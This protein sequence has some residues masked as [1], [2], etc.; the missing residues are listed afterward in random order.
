M[1][2]LSSLTHITRSPPSSSSPSSSSSRPRPRPRPPRPRRS[3]RRRP[4]PSSPS[5]SPSSCRRPLRPRPRRPRPR[6]LRG[7]VD[8]LS[9]LP[10]FSF[11]FFVE[12]SSSSG[13]GVSAGG[14]AATASGGIGGGVARAPI[15][16]PVASSCS[17]DGRTGVFPVSPIPA[18]ARA[19]EQLVVAAVVVTPPRRPERARPL[20]RVHAPPHVRRVGRRRR[21][22]AA[23]VVK[24]DD[25][26][27]LVG[28][29]AA[30]VEA[31]GLARLER[32]R[33]GEE[34]RHLSSGCRRRPPGGVAPLRFASGV[35]TYWSRRR[36]VL[37]LRRRRAAVLRL[38]GVRLGR[39]HRLASAPRPACG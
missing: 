9:F 31:V 25:D 27:A 14:G 21:R 7:V 3:R 4:C 32:R 2:F 37:P 20:D 38:G 35:H 36:A 24:V 10:F 23:H 19:R 22:A 16:E 1:A 28:G 39:R 30:F 29:G 18:S 8:L 6:R 13:G 33:A 15:G 12:P 34:A 17:I 5:S 11:D 26:D